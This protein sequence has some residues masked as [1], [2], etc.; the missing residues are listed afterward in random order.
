MLSHFH[1]ESTPLDTQHCHF[2]SLQLPFPWTVNQHQQTHREMQRDAQFNQCHFRCEKTIFRQKELYISRWGGERKEKKREKEVYLFS[3][4]SLLRCTSY[5]PH[6]FQS[7]FLA[8]RESSFT[9]SPT[10]CKTSQ[11]FI[12][13]P[14][15]SLHQ[16]LFALAACPVANDRG[17][18]TTS[19]ITEPIM[20]FLLCPEA[21]PSPSSQELWMH[22]VVI[23]QTLP[24][25]QQKVTGHLLPEKLI[26]YLYQYLFLI[27]HRETLRRNRKQHSG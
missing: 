27:N 10:Q 14:S 8:A 5:L 21:Q 11:V 19:N 23:Q 9:L 25:L 4:T 18:N 24:L 26:L 15:C 22:A 7:S 3:Y 17:K 13:A 6:L 20:T 1:L 12:S 2:I 16:P